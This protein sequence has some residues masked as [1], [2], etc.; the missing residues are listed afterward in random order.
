MNLNTILKCFGS[1]VV[2]YI[3]VA[4]CGSETRSHSN[5]QPPSDTADAFTSPVADAVA[6]TGTSC[7]TCAV[8]GPVTLAGPVKVVTADTDPAQIVGGTVT[9]TLQLAEGPLFVTDAHVSDDA[10][11]SAQGHLYIGTDAACAK[12]PDVGIT[13]TKSGLLGS[14][15]FVPAGK[16][17]CLTATVTISW[18]GF[19]PYSI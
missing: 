7:S 1:G 16:Y 12:S 14:R 3:V 19:R 5:L 17:L 9:G 2:V 18:L 11:S 10:V 4:A 13:V 6:Q 8:S 15:Y